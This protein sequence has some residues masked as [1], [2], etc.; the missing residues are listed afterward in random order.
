MN[1]GSSWTKLNLEF[2]V[3]GDLIEGKNGVLYLCGLNGTFLKSKD[4]GNNWEPID[5]GIN[6]HLYQIQQFQDIFYFRGQTIAKTNILKTQEFEIPDINDFVVYKENI[7]IGFGKQYEQGFFPIGAMFIS[8]N[9]GKIWSTTL[10]KEFNTIRLS[11]LLTQ[12]MV[13]VLQM[14]YLLEKNI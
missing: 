5:L 4:I 1:N 6:S 10:F 9:S 3:W 8:N 14:D 12:I 2:N 11:I 13:L 7:V